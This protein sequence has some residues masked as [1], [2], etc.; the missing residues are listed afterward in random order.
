M[1]IDLVSHDRADGNR[2]DQENERHDGHIHTAEHADEHYK[3]QAK[4]NVNQGIEGGR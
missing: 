2:D 3:G 1:E 4:G